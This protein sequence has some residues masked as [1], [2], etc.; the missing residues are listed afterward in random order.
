MSRGKQKPTSVYELIGFVNDP[1]AKEKF[2]SLK[3]YFEALE[4][5]KLKNFNVA[6][7]LFEKSFNETQDKTSNVYANRCKFLIE[8]PPDENWDGV[9]NLITK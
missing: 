4:N 2:E 3:I 7:E 9:F 6:K 1:K 5:Y 8:N